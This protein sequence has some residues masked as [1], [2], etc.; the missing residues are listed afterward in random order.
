MEAALILSMGFLVILVAG[1]P[2]LL[3]ATL[4]A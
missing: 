1:L 2:V 3:W 4:R